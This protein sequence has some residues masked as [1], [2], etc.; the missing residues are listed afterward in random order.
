MNKLFILFLTVALIFVITGCGDDSSEKEKSNGT[1]EQKTELNDDNSKTQEREG[2]NV[3]QIGETAQIISDLYDFPYEVTVNSFELTT[4]P[5]DGV[6]LEEKVL[7]VGEN[8]RFA[9]V[10]V[11]IKNVSDEAF[12]PNEMISAQLI[13][14]TVGENSYDE[15][16]FTDRNKELNPGEEITGNLVY[17]SNNFVKE[18]TLYL[19][20]EYMATDEETR[21]KLPVSK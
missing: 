18:D 17:L 11:T 20:Y 2:K 3:Y 19:A 6:K 13:G 4:E 10:N 9:V 15:E 7:E 14:E 21:F 16:F 1:N 5:V 8:D 12:V